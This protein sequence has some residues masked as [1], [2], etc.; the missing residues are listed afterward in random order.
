[1]EN[2]EA[3]IRLENIKGRISWEGY[4][5]DCDAIE[6]AINTI[7]HVMNLKM[8]LNSEIHRL[9]KLVIAKT[10]SD[11]EMV[12]TLVSLE[13]YSRVL[14]QLNDYTDCIHGNQ[15]HIF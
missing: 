7:A 9:E 1:M 10:T 13:C 6:I 15:I 3:I 4:K 2:K 5:N 8:D 14:N 11:E 12:K